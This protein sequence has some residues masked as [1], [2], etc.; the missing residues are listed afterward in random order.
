MGT[1]KQKKKKKKKQV[2]GVE[3]KVERKKRVKIKVA[4]R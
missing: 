4:E 1:H 2:C 3:N